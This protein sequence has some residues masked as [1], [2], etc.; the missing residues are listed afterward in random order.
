[1]VKDFF[2]SNKLDICPSCQK[3][4]VIAGS[5]FNGILLCKTCTNKITMRQVNQAGYK[6]RGKQS[7][8]KLSRID[9]VNDLKNR[10]RMEEV[11]WLG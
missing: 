4:N 7:T 1:M 9:R 8:I 5:T 11:K 2:T 10:R 6:H 3:S